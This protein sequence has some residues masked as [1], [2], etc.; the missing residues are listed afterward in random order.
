[1]SKI[2]AVRARQVLDSRGNPTVECDVKT[3]KGVY[4]AS[5]P[6]GASTGIHEAHE[7]RDRGKKYLGKGVSKAVRNI[8]VVI[9][10]KLKGKNPCKQEEIDEL[11]IKL[12]GTRNKNRLGANAILAASM[13]VCRAGGERS[14]YKHIGK[15]YG[16]KKFT[17]PIPA[18]NIINGGKH[19]GNNIAIQEYQI[20]P[21]GA[22]SFEEALRIGSEIYHQLKKTLEHHYGKQATN[23]GDEGGFAPQMENIEQPFEYITDAII[24]TGYWKKVKIGIDAAA[25]EFWKHKDYYLD[26]KQVSPE[27]LLEKYEALADKYPLISIEDPFYEEDFTGFAKLMHRLPR[28]QVIGDDLLCTNPKRI[29]KAIEK[30]SCN[31]LLLKMNQIGTVTEA[32]AAAKLAETSKWNVQVS[33]RSGET[34]DDFIADLAVGIASGQIKSGAPCRGERLAKYNQLLRIEEELG[35]KATYAGKHVKLA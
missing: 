24:S 30:H 18:F 31:C 4:R 8:N 21:T 9:A 3:G 1:M 28:M 13:A 29:K 26:G 2:L 27:K 22:K 19:A 25:S 5:V 33:H 12:D 17:L 14:L 32:L 7:L 23:V 20:M 11:M 35:R 16:N 6:S 15:L 34:T 10:K